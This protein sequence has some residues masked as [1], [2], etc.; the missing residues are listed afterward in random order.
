MEWCDQAPVLAVVISHT[1]TAN[2]D[3]NPTHTFDA[4]TS[5]GYLALEAVNQGLIT[6]AMGGFDKAKSREALEVPDDY[7]LHAVIAI[8]YHG[9]K[10]SLSEKNQ[11]REIPSNRRPVNESVFEGRFDNK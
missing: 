3:N 5:W 10:E 11:A 1:K 7:E 9:E 2:G 4:G 8:G 6:H